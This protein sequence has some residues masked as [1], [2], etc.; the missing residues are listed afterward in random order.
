LTQ[1][2]VI[3]DDVDMT[4]VLKLMLE[5][6]DFKVTVTNSS[7]EGVELARRLNPDVVVLDLLMPGM[8][9]WQT[10]RAIR[11][12][13]QV[14]ILILSVMN[15]PG[16][17]EQAFE[18]GADDYLVKPVANSVLV[19]HLNGLARR[20]RAELEAAATFFNL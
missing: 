3:D 13:S 9:G 20:A 4:D 14:P 12:F 5:R 10:C 6:V 1:V 18:A 2:L 8:D 15:N 7:A 11:R 16:M 17:L 19:A